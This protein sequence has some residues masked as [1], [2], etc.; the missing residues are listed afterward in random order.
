[1]SP[2]DSGVPIWMQHEYNC[3]IIAW[4]CQTCR[5]I[6]ICKDSTPF[7]TRSV[8]LLVHRYGHLYGA[9]CYWKAKNMVVNLACIDEKLR[10][11]NVGNF[12]SCSQF[13]SPATKLSVESTCKHTLSNQWNTIWGKTWDAFL[14]TS[15]HQFHKIYKPELCVDI[16]KSTCGKKNWSQGGTLVHSSRQDACR[17]LLRVSTSGYPWMKVGVNCKLPNKDMTEIKSNMQ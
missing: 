8:A 12:F 4:S 1:M 14:A 3:Y 6:F 5:D 16:F 2:A 17:L 15:P 13:W 10:G 9:W 7:E 11:W